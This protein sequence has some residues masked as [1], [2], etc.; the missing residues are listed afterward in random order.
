[1]GERMH[2]AI[3]S[4]KKG[5]QD[6]AYDADQNRAPKSA[7][8]TIHMK[9]MHELVDEQ[10]HQSI[11]D[12]DENAKSENNQR[13]HEQEQNGTE[14]CVKD[15][16]KKRGANERRGAIITNA[17]DQGRRDHDGHGRDCP[18]ENKMSHPKTTTVPSG[19]R[20]PVRPLVGK[21]LAVLKQ[22]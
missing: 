3:A 17:A 20:L 19:F 22:K 2:A 16:K 5:A 6:P 10:K 14:E 12:K 18:S 13:S 4:A 8:E 9:A 7:P 21:G 1:M 15:S 11:D